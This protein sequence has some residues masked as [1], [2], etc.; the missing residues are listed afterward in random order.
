MQAAG[1]S[2]HHAFLYCRHGQHRRRVS[3][4]GDWLTSGLF[5]PSSVRLLATRILPRPATSEPRAHTIECHY[6]STAISGSMADRARSLDAQVSQVTEISEIPR[7]LAR[8]VHLYLGGEGGREAPVATTKTYVLCMPP[9]RFIS[10]RPCAV[11]RVPEA[12]PSVGTTG[13]RRGRDKK[14]SRGA[15][16][17]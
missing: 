12:G 7:G 9:R 4:Q 17:P 13:G 11:A 1:P 14:R 3:G 10:P 6:S 15:R 5:L 16:E 8:S 2:R